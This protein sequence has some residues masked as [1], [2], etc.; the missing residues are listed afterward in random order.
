MET[1]KI[2]S[3]KLDD[4]TLKSK[5]NVMDDR[6][7]ISETETK[8]KK[9]METSIREVK[10]KKKEKKIKCAFCNEK[11][12]LFSILCE[13]GNRYCTK[14][15]SRVS[16]ECIKLSENQM[17]KKKEIKDNNPKMQASKMVKIE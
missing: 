7:E 17:K 9:C 12:G 8:S 15:S 14:H 13:C 10:K 3:P 4:T 5:H 16:H 6:G 11:C 1:D 2:N